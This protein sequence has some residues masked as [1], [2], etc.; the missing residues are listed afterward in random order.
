MTNTDIV[1]QRLRDIGVKLTRG[2][3]SDGAFRVQP[4][5]TGCESRR[6][7]SEW[8]QYGQKYV[9]CYWYFDGK[10]GRGI[11]LYSTVKELAACPIDK[12]LLEEVNDDWCLWLSVKH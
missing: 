6:M 5:M 12:F 3:Q 1:V 10:N 7:L 2:S 4:K 8:H 9:D 11:D